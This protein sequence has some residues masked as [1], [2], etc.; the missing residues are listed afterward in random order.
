MNKIR[1]DMLINQLSDI[2][3]EEQVTDKKVANKK[4]YI[5]TIYTLI[6]GIVLLN[7]VW[8]LISQCM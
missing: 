2:Q 8:W 6:G 7:L 1:I 4:I 3:N 5:R